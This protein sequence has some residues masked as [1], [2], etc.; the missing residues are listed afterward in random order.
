MMA[1]QDTLYPV[2]GSKSRPAAQSTA[3]QVPERVTAELQ[4][5]VK[6][7]LLTGF[8]ETCGTQDF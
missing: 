3:W 6:H 7:Y 5:A 2:A 4:Q 1:A 8:Q